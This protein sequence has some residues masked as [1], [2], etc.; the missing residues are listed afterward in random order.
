MK[1][2]A[3]ITEPPRIEY[4]GFKL[5]FNKKGDI[6]RGVISSVKYNFLYLDGRKLFNKPNALFLIKKKFNLKSK[7]L[8]GPGFRFINRKKLIIS[9]KQRI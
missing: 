5:I 3:K 4:K 2:S 8:I 9:L 6:C 1:G 7:Y